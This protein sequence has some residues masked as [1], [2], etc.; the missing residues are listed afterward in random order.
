VATLVTGYVRLNNANRSHARYL[1]LGRRL[2]GLGLPTVAYYDGHAG[3]LLPT[4]RTKVK[5]ASLDGCWM[6]A[7]AAESLPPPGSPMKDT[8]A[9][10]AVQ[11]Q[12]TEWIA[13]AAGAGDVLVWV[14]F[15]IFHLPCRLTDAHVRGMFAAVEAAPPDRITLPGIW[16]MR[17]RPMVNFLAPAWYVAGGVA[18]VPA[19]LATWFHETVVKYA[20]LQMDASGRTTW[21]VNT[22]SAIVRDHPDRFAVYAA[23]HDQTLFTNYGGPPP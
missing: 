19:H 9:Y 15:G 20:T 12:K 1:E 13:A 3:E 5:P 2:I 6:A 8:T 11:H 16:P 4:P 22:W 14:D 23:D 21:E 17:G 18:V 10:C 7:A